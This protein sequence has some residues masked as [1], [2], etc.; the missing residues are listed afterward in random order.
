MLHGTGCYLPRAGAPRSGGGS[1]LIRDQSNGRQA[2]AHGDLHYEPSHR[3]HPGGVG[4]YTRSIIASSTRYTVT[5]C[6]P[7]RHTTCGVRTLLRGG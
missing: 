7:G 6:T 2:E 4:G 1:T 5:E 3:C